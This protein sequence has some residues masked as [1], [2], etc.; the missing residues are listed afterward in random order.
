MYAE[1]EAIAIVQS[2]GWTTYAWEYDR[3]NCVSD[4]VLDI[5]KP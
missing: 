1:L 2:S 4:L 3:L 5:P